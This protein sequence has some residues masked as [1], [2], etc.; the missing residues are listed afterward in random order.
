M[1]KRRKK[2]KK[3]SKKK[4]KKHVKKRRV[5]TKQRTHL[6]RARA[7]RGK[8]KVAAAMKAANNLRGFVPPSVVADVKDSVAEA[9]RASM[10][11][12]GVPSDFKPKRRRGRPRKRR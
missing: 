3:K 1:A 8:H 7:L 11:Y 9:M 2:A 4:A 10:S 12:G 5:S 6:A